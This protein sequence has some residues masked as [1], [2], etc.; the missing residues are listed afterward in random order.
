[1]CAA[2]GLPNLSGYRQAGPAAYP[3]TRDRSSGLSENAKSTGRGLGGPLARPTHR[4]PKSRASGLR[5]A[6][7]DLAW[8]LLAVAQRATCTWECGGFRAKAKGRA[9]AFYGRLAG[10]WKR[11]RE[12]RPAAFSRMRPSGRYPPRRSGDRPPKADMCIAGPLDGPI[13]SRAIRCRIELLASAKNA[14][15]GCRLRLDAP[16]L[17]RDIERVVVRVIPAFGINVIPRPISP[18]QIV[19]EVNGPGRTVSVSHRCLPTLSPFFPSSHSIFKTWA[20]SP[21]RQTI[22]SNEITPARALGAR[23]AWSDRGATRPGVRRQ[24]WTCSY[25]ISAKSS[26][27][28]GAQQKEQMGAAI[29]NN[30]PLGSWRTV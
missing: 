10:Y 18:T 7:L 13:H 2:P 12:G 15:G 26:M 8:G 19:P 30:Q 11:K 3:N 20:S 4:G 24:N 25:H 14:C 22:S 27:R 6:D 16:Q 1:V 21:I 9:S 29:H 5:W 23:L 28:F 17:R